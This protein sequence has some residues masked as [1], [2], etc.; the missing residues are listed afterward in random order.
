MKVLPILLGG[1][2]NCYSMA[3]AFY[4]A[5]VSHSVAL[6]RYRLGVTS[7]SRFAKQVIDKDMESDEGRRRAIYRVMSMY[8]GFR[9]ILVGCTDE[10]ASFL[11]R[12][13]ESFPEEVIIPSPS[14][15]ALAYADKEIFGAACAK[16]DIRV[17][18]TV[19]LKESESVPYVLPFLYPVVMKPAV[20]EEYWHHPFAGM[21]K[22]WFPRSRQEAEDI[23]GKMRAAGY[24]GTVLLQEKL[25]ICD[26][27]NYVLTVYSDRTGRARAMA[28]GRVLL[29]EHTPRGLGNHAAILTMPA[30]PIAK[31]LLAFLDEIG[32]SGFA[33]FDL[34]MHPHTGELY[35][36]EMNLRQGRSNHYM[37]AA[38]LNPAGLL[39]SD[40]CAREPLPFSVAIPDV[41]WHS[42]PLSVVYSQV[43]EG[44][45][46]D[47]LRRLEARG[48]AVS[49]L[50]IRA[51]LCGNPLRRLFVT[52]HERRVRK[53]SGEP[54]KG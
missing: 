17:P 9:P 49:P 8:P 16:N 43:K 48:R 26:T 5:G 11:I 54:A 32:Y 2:L 31:K 44:A 40:H 4:E 3:L 7:F 14:I 1:D 10:Y 47:R 53:R 52:E 37:T 46:C 30:P 42:V 25:P 20:S 23:L 12:E 6:G 13:R 27:D 45:L 18:R 50:H 39:L 36:L 51:E 38:G 21:R 15:E 35:V 41:L 33:N 22:V 19:V 24:R 34:I 28:Y 29:E